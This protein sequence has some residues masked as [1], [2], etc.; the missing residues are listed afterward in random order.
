M[1]ARGGES[2]RVRSREG[3]QSDKNH[4]SAYS[5]SRYQSHSFVEKGTTRGTEVADCFAWHW[6][7]FYVESCF[8]RRRPIRADLNSMVVAQPD[9][10]RVYNFENAKLRRFLKRVWYQDLPPDDARRLAADL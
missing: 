8:H 5:H 9:K 3:I 4:A 6:N 2:L 7:K 1:I 10:Y